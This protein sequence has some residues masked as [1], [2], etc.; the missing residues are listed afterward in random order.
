MSEGTRLSTL[1]AC[2]FVAATFSVFIR[3]A[4][5]SAR[6]HVNWPVALLCHIPNGIHSHNATK[7]SNIAKLG[8][9]TTVVSVALR[10]VI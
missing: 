4:T 3:W 6:M 9:N 8:Q 2:Q 1:L 7:T 5:G 10:P